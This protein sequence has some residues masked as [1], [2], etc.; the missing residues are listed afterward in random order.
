MLNGSHV[1]IRALEYDDLPHLWRWQNDR[2]V[3]DQMWID[4]TSL[5]AVQKEFEDELGKDRQKRFII[6]DKESGRPI[7]VIWYYNLRENHSAEIG[8]YIGEPELHGKGLGADAVVTF[9]R[10]LFDVK[11]LHRVGLSVSADNRRAVACYERCGFK[12]E[13]AL[14]E[15]CW[16]GGRYV[17]LVNMGILRHEMPSPAGTD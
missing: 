3:M 16:I 10:F 12:H 1:I 5:R 6:D 14:R 17:D 8:I 2:N 4:P 15:F 9:L 11:N 13:G 7:G